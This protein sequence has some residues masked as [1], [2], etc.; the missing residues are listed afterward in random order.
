[1]GKRNST[2][3]FWGF[4]FKIISTVL[5]LIIIAANELIS[6]RITGWG[7]TIIDKWLATHKDNIISWILENPFHLTSAIALI[8]LVIIVVD[9]YFQ[10][11]RPNDTKQIEDKENRQELL[12]KS[13]KPKIS[14]GPEVEKRYV[15]VTIEEIRTAFLHVENNSRVPITE[16]Y[17]TLETAEYFREPFFAPIPI[18][19]NIRLQWDEKHYPEK[20]C[21]LSI[22]PTETRT[23]R[24]FKSLEEKRDINGNSDFGFSFCEP[25]G[26][27]DG[28]GIYI[29][30]I[31]I[32]GKQNVNGKDIEIKPKYFEGYLY[33]DIRSDIFDAIEDYDE[34]KNGQTIKHQRHI[35]KEY[36]RPVMYFQEGKWEHDQRIPIARPIEESD[37]KQPR[38]TTQRKRGNPR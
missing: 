22:P 2:K 27:V 24:V 10:R 28:F 6:D 25:S 15:G 9:W 33:I 29:L 31:R 5:A 21:K 18:Y 20:D 36:T 19:K 7:N 13:P 23:V 26:K 8:I 32:D 3:N 37:E 11:R 1:M 12:T 34:I 4:P 38:P 30:R 35:N 16:C 14:L 17:A